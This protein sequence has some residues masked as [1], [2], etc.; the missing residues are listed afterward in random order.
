MWSPWS[1]MWYPILSL[2]F[3]QTFLRTGWR[4]TAVH[5]C[6]HTAAVHGNHLLVHV[7]GRGAR[8]RAYL[9]VDPCA[10]PPPAMAD[11]HPRC[12]PS[13]QPRCSP[14]A[15]TGRP[16]PGRGSPLLHRAVAAE[17]ASSR[18]CGGAEV[19]IA[20]STS[21]KVH[22]DGRAGTAGAL[23]EE[24]SQTQK[25]RSPLW[26]PRSLALGCF[27]NRASLPMEHPGKQTSRPG[28]QTCPR[29]LCCFYFGE[30][31]CF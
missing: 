8:L 21:S 25:K 12:R 1:R 18:L 16:N 6:S 23:R 4:H 31:M 17:A 10:V 11:G 5:G 15:T 13:R 19:G 14:R 7:V 30:L 3:L 24:E 20:R 26:F 2:L 9:T 28:K 22:D 29:S 27:K